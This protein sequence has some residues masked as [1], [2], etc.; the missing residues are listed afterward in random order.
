MKTLPLYI[1]KFTGD[2]NSDEGS[3]M[4]VALLASIPMLI[5]FLF[6]VEILC[7]RLGAA[8]LAKGLRRVM[9]FIFDMGNVLSLH[10]DVLPPIAAELGLSVAQIVEFAG[11]G[12]DE[13]LTGAI[14]AGDMWKA[15]N[16]HFG[17]D[18]RED[19]LI[20][21]FH[22]VTDRRVERLILDLKAAG[23]RVVC[24][25][26]TFEKHYLYHLERGEYAVFDKV[27]AS[28]IIRIAKP[29]PAFFGHILKEEE[30][31]PEEAF[32]VDDREANVDAARALGI[33]SHVYRSFE[34][35]QA[36]LDGEAVLK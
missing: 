10:V 3:Q 6:D 21:H 22:P 12:F 1:V 17:T 7:R 9:L 25:T 27:Y 23:Q 26:N 8:L 4:A 28:H 33:R 5:L 14:T 30:R 34:G 11:R 20:T 29:S 24:G 2:I 19:L 15:F 36:W 32:F 31:R 35:L 18:V 13:M 16:K